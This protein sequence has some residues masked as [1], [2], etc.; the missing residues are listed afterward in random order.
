MLSTVTKQELAKIQ[1]VPIQYND[2]TTRIMIKKRVDI[3]L[4][5]GEYYLIQLSD[6]MINPPVNS[7]IN[8]NWNQGN[9]PHQ[10]YYK[11][12]INKILNNM[13]KVTGVS[14]DYDGQSVTIAQEFWSG[15]VPREEF[16][17]VQKL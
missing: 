6:F 15:W 9:N 11:V 17:I 1:E 5:E 13:V 16:V 2:A 12:E 10:R 3:K 8:S 4:T 14:F 7:V